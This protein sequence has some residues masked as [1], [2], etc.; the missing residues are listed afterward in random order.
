M[1]RL[2]LREGRKRARYGSALTLPAEASTLASTLARSWQEVTESADLPSELSVYTLSLTANFS[3][4]TETCAEAVSKKRRETF[5]ELTIFSRPAQ[6]GIRERSRRRCSLRQL[7]LLR[8]VILSQTSAP[9]LTSLR[10]TVGDNP[11]GT[12][13]LEVAKQFWRIVPCGDSSDSSEGVADTSAGLKLNVVDKES[14]ND[15]ATASFSSVQS[16]NTHAAAAPA[17]PAV[18][19][20]NDGDDD[21]WTPQATQTVDKYDRKTWVCQHQG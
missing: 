5:L 12:D 15:A 10:I 6:M 4:E 11:T 19:S 1:S 21:A 8:F 3:A 17:A 13:T 20:D 16:T 9:I 18:D 2:L 7:R 14:S